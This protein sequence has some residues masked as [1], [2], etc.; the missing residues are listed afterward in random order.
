[1]YQPPIDLPNWVMI[2]LA[3]STSFPYIR[4]VSNPSTNGLHGSPRHQLAL[5]RC[6]VGGWLLTSHSAVSVGCSLILVKWVCLKIGYPGYPSIHCLIIIFSMNMH[7]FWGFWTKPAFFHGW[8]VPISSPVWHLH[9]KCRSWTRMHHQDSVPGSLLGHP[10]CI[11]NIYNI[12]V[13]IHILYEY[14]CI[15][16]WNNII[17]YYIIS[18][19]IILY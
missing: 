8:N 6:E 1:M 7:F 17:L 16:I 14:V 13:Y 3:T 5:G 4:W 12:W 9:M 15:Y 11:S 10:W 18:Y 19:Y 2:H